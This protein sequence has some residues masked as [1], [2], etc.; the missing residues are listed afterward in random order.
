MSS[1]RQFNPFYIGPYPERACGDC[2]YGEYSGFT[3]CG[4]SGGNGPFGTTFCDSR[5]GGGGGGGQGGGG[6]RGGC[7]GRGRGGC[8]PSCGPRG[9]SWSCGPRPYS[10][11]YQF[12][13]GADSCMMCSSGFG[14]CGQS[15]RASCYSCC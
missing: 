9:G 1:C 4:W 7:G 11:C 5:Y 15:C 3:R 14:C 2:P 6:G 10:P 13:Y 8:A 12:P